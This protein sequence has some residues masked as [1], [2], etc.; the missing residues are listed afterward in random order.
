[1]RVLLI[2]DSCTDVY[3]YGDVKRLNP[4]AP[5]P[6]LE[7]KRE[8][9]TNGMA[10]N[11]F[12]NLKAFGLSVFMLTNEEKIIKTRY[13]H[14]KS[15]QQILRVDDEPEIKPLPYEPPFITD[16]SAYHKP[17]HVVPPKDWYD[18]MVI[19]DYDKGY[20]TQEKLF[21]LVDWFEGPVF[22][23]SKKTHLPDNC[24]VKVND[25]EY[26][27]LQTK[28][29]NVIITRG[30]EG[31]EYKDKLYPAERVNVFDVVGAGDT[32]LAALTYG[33]LKY[34]TIEEAIP[35]ANKA[36]AVA[37]SHRGTYIL[38]EEDVK[39]ILC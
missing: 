32:F 4:E 33:Y 24:Y 6:I 1:M 39:K 17:P 21:E 7:P 27:R 11:V 14:E 19:S 25:I 36:A 38:T 34:G 23:D 37:V 35:L 28:N 13:I 2:G 18:V 9:T 26:E 20:V 12:N 8:D 22:V 29:D 31:T 10:W 5:V 3:V 16:R 15:N 30:G